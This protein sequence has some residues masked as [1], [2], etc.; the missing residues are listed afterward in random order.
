MRDWETSLTDIKIIGRDVE[1]TTGGPYREKRLFR[2]H[3]VEFDWSLM[4]AV[5]NGL[6]RVQGCWTAIIGRPCLVPDEVFHRITIDGA[7][8]HMERALSG[9]WNTE[10]AFRVETLDALLTAVGRWRIPTLE[11]EDVSLSWV[12]HLPGE[13]GGGLV[14]QRYSSLDFSKV[15]IGVANL[16][17]PIDDRP[18]PTRVTF[19][20]QTADGT[21]SVAGQANIARWEAGTWSPS[22]DLTFRLVN[23][24]AATVARF[25]APDASVVPKGGAVDGQIRV[26]RDGTRTTVC[27]IDVTLRDV[28][29]AANPRSPYARAGGQ[30][31]DD[32]LRP[33][34]INQIV[35]RDC[36]VVGAAPDQRRVSETFQTMVTSGALANA[37][38]LVKGAAGFD[39]TTV[40]QGRAPTADEITAQVS[41]DLG[42]A[43]A[44]TR[45]AA[46]ANALTSRDASGGNAVS[47]G[48]KSVGRG[49]K[50]LFG[51]GKK[52]AG[53]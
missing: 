27:Q 22:Y 42:M 45:G 5:S 19:D 32:Q 6:A 23:V 25:S 53:Q 30:S 15:T 1:I 20:G 7:T 28:T 12:E 24:G 36:S 48:A 44:G 47:R 14:E 41:T 16:Q 21:V 50:H 46:V 43:L 18:N 31:L 38:P 52:P 26:A 39:E 34:R 13:S 9:A 3:A 49:I 10:D 33:V 37:P 8:L 51:G 35:S 17:L 2:A 40:V 29:Y 11:G 4:R